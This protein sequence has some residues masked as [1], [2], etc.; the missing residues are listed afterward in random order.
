[1]QLLEPKEFDATQDNATQ[2][3]GEELEMGNFVKAKQVPIRVETGIYEEDYPNKITLQQR[4][5]KR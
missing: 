3:P 1:M 5:I 2:A 4:I